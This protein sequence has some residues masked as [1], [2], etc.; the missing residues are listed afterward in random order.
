MPTAP[1]E[2]IEDLIVVAGHATYLGGPGDDPARDELWCLAP[3]QRGEPPRLVQHVRA[4]VALAADNPRALLVFSGGLT[5]DNELSRTE[6]EGYRQVADRLGWWGAPEVAGRQA[7][8]EFARD[9]F[10]N[11]LFSICRFHEWGGGFPLNVTVVSWRFK[12]ARFELHRRALRFP[13]P[14]FSFRGPNDPADLE[15]ALRG[16]RRRALE[17]FRA[18]PYG[19]RTAAERIARPDPTG[20][21]P[22]GE[23]FL[24]DK[25]RQRDPR[26]REPPYR[27]TCPALEALLDHR[28]PELFAGPLP[29]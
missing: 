15:A 13:R 11:L 21:G 25:R 9:S 27:R 7:R 5:R 3:F 6:A 2:R 19:T 22:D 10:E 28:G 20:P 26:G 14:R 1:R 24:G 12:R 16:E 18:D 4:G 23:V 17:P 8:E 29:W